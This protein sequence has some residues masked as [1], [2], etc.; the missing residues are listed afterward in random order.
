MVHSSGTSHFTVSGPMRDILKK[1]KSKRA[2][3]AFVAAA[4]AS[5]GVDAPPG[6]SDAK[7]TEVPAGNMTQ[8][9]FDEA[10]NLP[11]DG[12]WMNDVGIT[13][14]PKDCKA[15][16]GKINLGE[17]CPILADAVFQMVGEITDAQTTMAN[18]IHKTETHC[19][20][21]RENLES[22]IS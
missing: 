17:K 12:D 7:Q 18:F 8:E 1:F 22:Q 5:L 16:D 4:R 3:M 6:A 9:E 14:L 11:Q 13:E 19:Q 15:L 20:T 2:M 21:V 10:M